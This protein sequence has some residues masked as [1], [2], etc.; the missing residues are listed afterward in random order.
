LKAIALAAVAA[1]LVGCGSACYADTVTSVGQA[2]QYLIKSTGAERWV[3]ISSKVNEG[4]FQCENF[5]TFVSCPMPVWRQVLPGTKLTGTADA[6]A[7]KPYPLL[8]GSERKDYLTDK[9]VAAARRVLKR[10]GLSV[11][12]V[13]SQLVD[14]KDKSKSV[15]TSFELQVALNFNYKQ[16]P[17]LVEAYMV[18]VWGAGADKGYDFET[19]D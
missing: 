1:F 10:F 8:A 13:Y 9:Q 16:F 14:A 19:A 11:D 3:V 6:R 2:W 5:D 17:D 4:Y 12:D 18:E 7:D 15:G